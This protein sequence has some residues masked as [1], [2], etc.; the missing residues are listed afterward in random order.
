MS[1]HNTLGGKTALITGAARRIG[2][3]IAQQL[4]QAGMNVA[5]HYR[6]SAAAAAELNA[7][8]NQRRP[9]SSCLIQGDLLNTAALPGL[10]AQAQQ[11]WQRLDVLVNNASS[12]YPTPVATASEAQ[13]DD[14]LDSNLKAPFF[15]AQAALPQLREQQGSIIN[16]VDIH[17]ERPRA[18]HPIYSIAKAGLVMLTKSLAWELAPHVR[19]N[20]VAPGAILWAEN[21]TDSSTQAEIL[22]RIPLQRL[23]QLDDISQTVLFLLRDGVYINGQIVAVDGGRS[24]FM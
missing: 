20:G 19:V 4:H 3:Q 5:L 1:K 2:A 13:W 8:L 18:Q 16:I 22:A 14:L 15:L 21:E 10:I 17:A 6:S 24:L 9:A 7:K 23:G 11:P 12:F